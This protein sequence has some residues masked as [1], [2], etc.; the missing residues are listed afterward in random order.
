MEILVTL[1]KFE[2]RLL[3]GIFRQTEKRM[4]IPVA[5][6]VSRSG[7]IGVVAADGRERERYKI[8]YGATILVKDGVPVQ[9][10]QRLAKWDPHMHP[11]VTELAGYVKFQDFE[12]GVTVTRESDPVTGVT[13]LVITKRMARAALPS[14]DIRPEKTERA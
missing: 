1:Q 11:I 3:A 8:P 13:N 4:V 10:G 9:G 6:A 5:R 14:V 2:I 12:E 7:E